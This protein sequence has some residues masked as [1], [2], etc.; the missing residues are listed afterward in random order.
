MS[1]PKNLTPIANPDLSQEHPTVLEID[2]GALKHNLQV[3]KSRLQQKTKFLA[4][5][6]AFAYGSDALKIAQTLEEEGVDYLAVAYTSEGIALRDGGIRLPILVLHPQ[7]DQLSRCIDRCLEPSI[8][9]PR[10]LRAFVKT[11]EEKQQTDYPIHL[12]FNTGLNR[13]GF[14]ENDVDRVN[15]LLQNTRSIKVKGLLSHL[16]ASDDPAEKRFTETQLKQF[17]KI[18][19]ELV[20]KLGYQP[21]RHLLNSS[22]ILNYP[23]AQFEMVRSGI[24]LYG[25]GNAPEFDA[26]LKPL[27]R[28]RTVISQLHKIEPGESVGYNRAYK[29]EAYQLIATLPLGHAD[30]IGRQYGHGKG[31]V[32]LQGQLA[33]IIGNVCMDM[34]MV[35]VTGLDCKEGDP[36]IVF[37]PEHSAEDFARGAGTISYELL[38]G[39]SSRVP[40]QIIDSTR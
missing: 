32:W 40:R 3:L 7:P 5:V 35:D 34:L 8:Y 33:P 10:L 2:L 23:E 36:V 21:L 6:K 39:I 28:L 31:Q 25:Y 4:V 16:A 30:G 9:S 27:G 26:E 37:G 38:T 18:G 19:K 12:K 20:E 11:A 13:L 14:W 29:A 15:E 22:G 24:A 1:M 17:E